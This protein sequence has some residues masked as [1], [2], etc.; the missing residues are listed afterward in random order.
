MEQY[1]WKLPENASAIN[2]VNIECKR[3]L[4]ADYMNPAPFQ[5]PLERFQWTTTASYFMCLYTMEV[6]EIHIV[7]L[8]Q[9]INSCSIL[10]FFQSVGY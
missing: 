10:E 5:T 9:Q 8:E 4:H 1:K 6:S 7:I 3:L 2:V